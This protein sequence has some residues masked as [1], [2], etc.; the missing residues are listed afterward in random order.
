MKTILIFTLLILT[1]TQCN[2]FKGELCPKKQII[3]LDTSITQ[4]NSNKAI[5][6]KLTKDTTTIKDRR[7]VKVYT[8]RGELYLLDNN[9][10]LEGDTLELE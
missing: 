1:I 10:W 6:I 9:T 4:I 3:T 7:F 2:P 8:N 5:I